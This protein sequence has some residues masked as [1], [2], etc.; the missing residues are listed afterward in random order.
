MDDLLHDDA[1]EGLGGG[2]R[3]VSSH[4]SP[5]GRAG[6]CAAVS[7][8]PN[9]PCRLQEAEL[10]EDH[11]AGASVL[12]ADLTMRPQGFATFMVFELAM[13]NVKVWFAAGT[14]SK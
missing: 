9:E 1:A 7:A 8:C 14:I 11:V 2:A 13:L 6:S 5:S 12:S 3:R 4:T 10:G